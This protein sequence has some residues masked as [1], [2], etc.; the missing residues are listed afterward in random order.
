M[1]IIA[2]CMSIKQKF[3]NLKVLSLDIHTKSDSPYDPSID[4]GLREKNT[5]YSQIFEQM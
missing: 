1:V 3:L 4:Y 2:M 5:S